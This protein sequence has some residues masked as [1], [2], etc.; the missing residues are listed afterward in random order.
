MTVL[1]MRARVS[2]AVV[3][4]LLVLPGCEGILGLV[5]GEAPLRPLAVEISKSEGTLM[6]TAPEPFAGISCSTYYSPDD[7]SK[8]RVVWWVTC[9]ND[10]DCMR[11]VQYGASTFEVKV[12]AEALLPGQCYICNIG[13]SNGRGDV[14]FEVGPDGTPG[15]CRKPDA[16]K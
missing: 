4:L 9:P 7:A 11:S 15:P 8:I 6:V 5:L 13:G 2:V 10:T 14:V 3:A 16:T 12:A 1:L